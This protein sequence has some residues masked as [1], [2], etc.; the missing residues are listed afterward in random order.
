M[1]REVE[2]VVKVPVVVVVQ[3][4]GLQWARTGS[5]SCPR[6]AVVH[7]ICGPPTCLSS[8]RRGGS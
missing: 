7:Q 3:V 2:R 4:A 8:R 1:G 6:L 5:R